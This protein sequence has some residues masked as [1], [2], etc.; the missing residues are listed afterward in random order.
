M[1]LGKDTHLSDE[2]LVD[3]MVS[4]PWEIQRARMK[5]TLQ[6]LCPTFKSTIHNTIPLE[7]D[8]EGV[9]SFNN[10]HV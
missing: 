5:T 10:E 4:N 6:H 7:S 3:T 8:R 2:E 9:D 1:L